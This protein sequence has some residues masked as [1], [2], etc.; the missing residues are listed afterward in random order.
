MHGARSWGVTLS[1]RKVTP[2]TAILAVLFAE[3]RLDSAAKTTKVCQ[4]ALFDLTARSKPNTLCG[5][6]LIDPGRVGARFEN[7]VLR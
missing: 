7:M 2:V 5:N 6:F 4:Y 1:R 3:L